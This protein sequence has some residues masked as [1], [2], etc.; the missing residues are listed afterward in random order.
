MKYLFIIMALLMPLSA[1][2]KSYEV[3][4]DQSSITFAATHA[5]DPFDGVFDEWSADIQFDKD[6]LEASNVTVTFNTASAKTGNAM[7]DGTLP[8]N[9]WFDVKNHPEATFQSASFTQNEN[10]YSVTGDLTI[11]GITNPI[12]FNFTL[13]GDAPTTM[14]AQFLIDRLT[15]KIGE[16]SDPKAEWVSQNI[17]IEI[18]LVAN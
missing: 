14:T 9:D 17:D 4:Y 18:N 15:Y 1:H 11:K 16:R 5:G 7:Y 3:D 6:N 8:T 10:D 12:M 2:A 13:E